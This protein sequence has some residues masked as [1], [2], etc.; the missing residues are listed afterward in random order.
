MTTITPDRDSTFE[1]TLAQR[2]EALAHANEIR[3]ARARLKKR[4]GPGSNGLTASQIIAD[5]PEYTDTM[6]VYELLMAIPKWGRTK[7]L[8]AM[9]GVDIATG[10]TVGGL[11]PRQR[12]ELLAWLNGR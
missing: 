1:R 2:L 8:N 6:K 11:S 4:I 5:P 12:R 7:A 3:T 9:R 10:K